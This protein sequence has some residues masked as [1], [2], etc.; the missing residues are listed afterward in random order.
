[1]KKRMTMAT[2]LTTMMTMTTMMISM[3]VM[4]KVMLK[5]MCTRG[6]HWKDLNGIDRL[7]RR[8]DY[9]PSTSAVLSIR[10]IMIFM[11]I[12]V[13]VKIMIYMNIMMTPHDQV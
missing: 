12:V 1:M 7:G 10:I 4:S 9:E 11:I 8:L 6:S 2:V 5:V 13:I 3:K